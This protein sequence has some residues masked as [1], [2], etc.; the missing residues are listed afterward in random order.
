MVVSIVT[1]DGG[2]GMI[3]ASATLR[4]ETPRTAPVASTTACGSLARA[5]AHGA[6]GVVI[7]AHAC[8]QNRCERVRVVADSVAW[9]HLALVQRGERLGAGQPAC[10]ADPFD[11]RSDV[12][13]VGEQIDVDPR[14]NLR[15]PRGERHS[16]PRPRLEQPDGDLERDAGGA[17]LAWGEC[18]REYVQPRAT[19]AAGF[20]DGHHRLHG[21]RPLR[22]LRGI[23]REHRAE[24][25]LLGEVGADAGDISD[26]VD[27]ERG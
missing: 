18:G 24:E 11:H 26:H 7:E 5:H 6:V 22:Q 21:R 12:P 25:R 8:L 13:R 10:Q 4:L 23:A 16:P 9:E 1:L 20:G 19:R 3:D 27:S 15:V 2:V 17:H 14:R